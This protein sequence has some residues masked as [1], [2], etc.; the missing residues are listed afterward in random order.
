VNENTVHINRHESDEKPNTPKNMKTDEKVVALAKPLG[1]TD[2]E[3]QAAKAVMR[4]RK[5][6]AP[7]L[8]I[9][10]VETETGLANLVSPDHPDPD[11]G[12]V[13]LMN[14]FATGDSDFLAEVM[15]QL[16]NAS[17][18]D[19]PNEQRLNFM[20]AVIKGIKPQDQL[21][22]LLA[23]QMA[24]I[25]GLVMDFSSRLRNGASD[26][27][28]RNSASTILNKLCRTFTMQIQALKCY[29]SSG[30]QTVRVE[31]VNVNAGGQAIVGNVSTRGAGA[32]EK[33]ESTS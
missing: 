29:R 5:I 24:A 33:S 14:A 25:H 21:E 1:P 4:A 15:T 2:A 30:E 20:V 32:T 13:L 10:R 16:Y 27:E 7:R 23:S 19:E 28:W 17:S 6:T 22:T 9:T 8:K 3:K 12:N 18:K 31:H 11:Y 26:L